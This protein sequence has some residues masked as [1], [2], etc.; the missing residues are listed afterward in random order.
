M[1]G[2]SRHTSARSTGNVLYE[3][4]VWK[5]SYIRYNDSNG[6]MVQIVVFHSKNLQGSKRK[7]WKR[8][9]ILNGLVKRERE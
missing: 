1:P 8:G 3:L 7:G 9:Q 4:S 6:K 5:A 2:S